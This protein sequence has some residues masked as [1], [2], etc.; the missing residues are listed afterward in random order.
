MKLTILS[1]AVGLFLTG[2]SALG[3]ETQVADS[4][5]EICPLL[6][7]QSVPDVQLTTVKGRAFDLTEAIAEKPT[8]LI[9]Y[10]GGWCPFCNM[11][12]AELHSIQD[13]LRELGYQIL[14]ISM[15]RPAKL[16]ES[17]TEHDL[18]YTL[19]SDSAAVATK[20]FGLA[21]RATN[22]NTDRLESYSGRDHHILPV[23]AAFIV[24][25]DGMIKFEYINPNYKVR[26][27]SE[28]I[29]AAAKAEV[30]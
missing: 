4:A 11:H 27:K 29:L 10:R 22:S 14:A 15:D 12:L 1:I 16:R 18:G 6:V 13:D 20:A 25:T 5:E 17:L 26:V 9:F 30:Q 2:N 24:G 7:G 8:L 21:F 3:A 28:V 23:P 19:L